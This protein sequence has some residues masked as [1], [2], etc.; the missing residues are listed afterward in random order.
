MS[1]DGD[2]G[3]GGASVVGVRAVDVAVFVA[4]AACGDGV[5]AGLGVDAALQ[6]VIGQRAALRAVVSL[7][8]HGILRGPSVCGLRQACSGSAPQVG[9]VM[10]IAPQC[11]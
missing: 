7:S 11:S 10:V 4:V 2:G 3:S 6:R 1:A 9:H 8:T 5:A